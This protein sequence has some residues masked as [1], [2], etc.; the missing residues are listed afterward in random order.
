MTAGA[1]HTMAVG[2]AGD[3]F[4][5]CSSAQ[6]PNA[7]RNARPNARPNARAHALRAHALRSHGSGHEDWWL[8]RCRAV[9]AY[10]RTDQRSANTASQGECGSR[11]LTVA[12]HWPVG[13]RSLRRTAPFGSIEHGALG[14]SVDWQVKSHVT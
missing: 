11:R 7:R 3:L 8:L 6:S 4:S 13:G 1:W 9:V 12:T 2:A 14:R 10:A 5:E